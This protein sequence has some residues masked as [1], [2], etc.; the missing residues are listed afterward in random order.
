LEEHLSKRFDSDK[1]VFSPR[2]THA[3]LEALRNTQTVETI[4]LQQSYKASA[5]S[6]RQFLVAKRNTNF[7]SRLLGRQKSKL[8][9]TVERFAAEI[10]RRSLR[11]MQNLLFKIKHDYCT[12]HK[13]YSQI[14]GFNAY[15]NRSTLAHPPSHQQ[16]NHAL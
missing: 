2:L 7:L 15:A 16:H 14:H 3:Y 10:D 5:I 11:E 12:L 9:R 13:H 4:R 8:T 6:K 1:M